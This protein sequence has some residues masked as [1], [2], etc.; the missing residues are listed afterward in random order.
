M[1]QQYSTSQLIELLANHG[2]RPSSQRLAVLSVLVASEEHPSAEQ[3]F[4]KL[5]KIQPLIS[6]ST[7]YNTVKLF[8]SKKLIDAVNTDP[9]ELRFDFIETP[10]AHFQCRQCGTVYDVPVDMSSLPKFNKPGFITE[11]TSLYYIGLC[12]E[13][14]KMSK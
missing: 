3:I 14:A 13:C 1:R 4:A 12:P 8:V 7:V 10:H 9:N 5:K 2:I 11:G 6:R